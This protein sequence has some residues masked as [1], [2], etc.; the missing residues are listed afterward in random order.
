MTNLRPDR[1]WPADEAD[2]EA[3][4]RYLSGE[5]SAAESEA[6]RRRL[7]EQPDAERL[8]ALLDRAGQAV[9]FKATKDMDVEA[10]LRRV[11]ARMANDE[12][13]PIMAAA[14]AVRRSDAPR[15]AAYALPIAAGLLLLV[16]GTYVW[17]NRP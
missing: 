15:W 8:A 7:A 9:A 3:L 10:A 1:E 2:W 6:V 4:G 5:S 11:H 13:R 16:G 12:V 14:V 17:R